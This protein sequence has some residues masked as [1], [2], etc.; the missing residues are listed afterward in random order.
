MLAKVIL[1]C[2]LI[3]NRGKLDYYKLYLTWFVTVTS[4]P[5]S[6]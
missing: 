4:C 1:F 5:V 2:F 6:V 3:N